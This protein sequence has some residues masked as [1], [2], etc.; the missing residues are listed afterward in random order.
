MSTRHT[1]AFNFTSSH[2]DEWEI[3]V[4]TFFFFFTAELANITSH[5]SHNEYGDVVQCVPA[6]FLCAFPQSASPAASRF[7]PRSVL[8][9]LPPD[10]QKMVWPFHLSQE[11]SVTHS[12]SWELISSL[13]TSH[14]SARRL[15]LLSACIRF[16]RCFTRKV[17]IQNS[18]D[19]A[20]L[21]YILLALWVFK[22]RTHPL[23]FEFD[24][25][26]IMEYE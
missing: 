15:P 19:G 13:N 22:N 1:G 16:K 20:H 9:F 4:L 24:F 21:W 6:R 3:I 26:L 25:T 7:W 10:S 23:P 14:L 8:T 11:C 12:A 5:L 18:S 2:E 17:K